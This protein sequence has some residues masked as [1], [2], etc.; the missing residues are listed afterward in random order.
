MQVIKIDRQAEKD[1]DFDA[2]LQD[3]MMSLSSHCSIGSM[4]PLAALGD[5]IVALMNSLP[6]DPIVPTA[7][8]Y[9]KPR[10]TYP[11]ENATSSDTTNGL[12]AASPEALA[13]ALRL[14]GRDSTTQSSVEQTD[15]QTDELTDG[16]T[17]ERTVESGE[18]IESGDWS[19]DAESKAPLG[20]QL[21][22]M[23]GGDEAAHEYSGDWSQVVAAATPPGVQLPAMHTYGTVAMHASGGDAA[24]YAS[25]ASGGDKTVVASSGDEAT[26]ALR[27]TSGKPSESVHAAVRFGA[28]TPSRTLDDFMPDVISKSFDADD[29]ARGYASLA[30]P[31]RPASVSVYGASAGKGVFER[32]RVGGAAAVGARANPAAAESGVHFAVATPVVRMVRNV[33]PTRTFSP[34]ALDSQESLSSSKW[35]S[36]GL[37]LTELLYVI[38]SILEGILVRCSYLY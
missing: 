9:A 4:A 11:S 24:M 17:D 26:S 38:G 18:S 7:V 36:A 30:V 5:G 2:R 10:V 16:R 34:D 1:T 31:F 29:E 21:P 12:P 25:Y 3:K 13:T 8:T 27:G 32:A 23:H 35:M 6:I 22:V 28:P 20:M 19:H 33:E 15:K 37:P 14:L